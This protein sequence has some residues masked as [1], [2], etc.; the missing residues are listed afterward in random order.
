[1][2]IK[3]CAGPG[4]PAA[5]VAAGRVRRTSPLHPA[6]AGVGMYAF[7]LHRI[8]G[9]ALVFYVFLHIPVIGSAVV[10]ASSFDAVMAFL[11]T[12]FWV[13]LDVG[14]LAAV[15]FHGL[16]GV[17]LLLFDLGVLVK[18]QKLVFWLVFAVS[19]AGVAWCAWIVLPLVLA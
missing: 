15:I 14:L 3:A 17:R 13:I 12:K 5:G 10:G 16:N 4:G 8:T 11:H 9:L 7:L 18:Q 1:M 6:N 19:A 2:E